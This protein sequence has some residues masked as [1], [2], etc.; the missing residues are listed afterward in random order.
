MGENIEKS[1]KH[2]LTDQEAKKLLTEFGI[3]FIPEAYVNRPSKVAAAAAEFGLPV[4]VKAIGRN[5]LHKSDRGLVHLNLSDAGSIESAVK[6]IV[7]EASAELD[8]FLIQPQIRLTR[9][10]KD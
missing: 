9:H 10:Q 5:L 6:D 1:A 7:A 2:A 3:P 8:G 4:V